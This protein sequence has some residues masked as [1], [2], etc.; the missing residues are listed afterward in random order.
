MRPKKDNKLIAIDFGGEK[1]YFT[2]LNRVGFKVGLATASIKWAI[3]HNNTLCSYDGR[4]F[5]VYYIDGSDIPYKY[6]NN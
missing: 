2:S 4:D 3:D 1:H 6:I 5:K